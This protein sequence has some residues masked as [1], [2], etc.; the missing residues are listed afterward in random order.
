MSRG[1]TR[2]AADQTG[3][4]SQIRVIRANPRQD[5]C[6]H[7]AEFSPSPESAATPN[8]PKTCAQEP[9]C[10]IMR[11]MRAVALPPPLALWERV[12]VRNHQP[13]PNCERAKPT[14]TNESI[15]YKPLSTGKV[16]DRNQVLI[17]HGLGDLAYGFGK[18]RH[19]EAPLVPSG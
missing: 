9:P 6:A 16:A 2:I 4:S 12:R 3:L 17:A 13:Q 8:V 19:I 11:L 5:L 1:F 15:L 14:Q 7:I 18:P 10:M